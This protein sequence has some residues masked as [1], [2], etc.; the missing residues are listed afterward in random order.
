MTTTVASMATKSSD[1]D[2]Q[3]SGANLQT[4][5]HTPLPS[6][7]HKNPKRDGRLPSGSAPSHLPSWS[8]ARKPLPSCPDTRY[9]LGIHMTLTEETGAAP[10]PLHVWIAPIVED[11]LHHGRTG[12]PKAIVSGPGRSVLLYGRWSLGESLSIGEV[13]CCFYAYRSRHLGW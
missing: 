4:E 2:D 13:R 8:P 6:R 5:G 12:L 11:M 7:G 1:L 3:T 9:C 10:P